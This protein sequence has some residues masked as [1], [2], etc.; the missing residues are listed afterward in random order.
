MADT[1]H[2]HTNSS[3]AEQR[4]RTLARNMQTHRGVSE[5][6]DKNKTS[7]SQRKL[8]RNRM[9]R[10]ISK[11]KDKENTTLAEEVSQTQ[12]EQTIHRLTED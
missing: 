10:G 6:Q 4:E 8:G 1:H 9:T 2:V 11:K 3:R 7:D 12:D 5:K